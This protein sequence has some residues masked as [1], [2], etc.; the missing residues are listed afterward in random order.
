MSASDFSRGNEFLRNGQLEEAI[1]AYQKAIGQNRDFYLVYQNLGEALEKLGRFDEAIAAYRRAVELKPE[2]AWSYVNLSRVLRQVGRVDEAEN[3]EEQGGGIHPKLGVVRPVTTVDSSEAKA[4]NLAADSSYKAIKELNR[5]REYKSTTSLFNRS[6]TDNPNRAKIT[7]LLLNFKRY[8]NI[9]KIVESL[10][11]QT[12]PVEIFLWDNS[13]NINN[14]F[15]NIDLVFRASQNQGC[16][17]RWFMAL[18]A[19]TPYIMT[20]DD[21]FMITHHETIANIVRCLEEQ[22]DTRT[23][24]GLEGVVVN[25]NKSY[26]DHVLGLR[27]RYRYQGNEYGSVGP[28]LIYRSGK[29][30]DLIR[31]ERVHLV[32]GRLMATRTENIFRHVDIPT[33]IKERED[34]IA[35]SAM[36][37]QKQRIHLIPS[38][39][40]DC[41]DEL[42]DNSTLGNKDE[43]F[44]YHS[45]DMALKRYFI[46]EDNLI[47]SQEPRSLTNQVVPTL[48]LHQSPKLFIVVPFNDVRFLQK[49]LQ[50]IEMQTYKN[51]KCIVVDDFC[52]QEYSNEI[53]KILNCDN[54]ELVVNRKREY[55]LKSRVVA[56]E[57]CVEKEWISDED[58]I[59][60]VDGDDWLAHENSLLKIAE[61]YSDGRTWVTYGGAKRLEKGKLSE[62]FMHAL[63][64]KQIE[65]KWGLKVSPKYPEEVIAKRSY[66][67]YPWGACHCRT[68]KYKL[69]KNIS[70]DDFQDASGNYFRYATDMAIFVPILEMAGNRI[71]YIDETIYIYNRE[72]GKKN[73]ANEFKDQHSNHNY[74]RKKPKYSVYIENELFLTTK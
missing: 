15:P 27:S 73:V 3:A 11:S 66:R 10:R 2:A 34:D 29:N 6:I 68:F 28:S 40:K 69:Y 31:S 56:I 20:H 52:Q 65:E 64:N 21:D 17:P 12:I 58:V 33:L 23:I 1:A 22:Q 37:G 46:Q 9:P 55:A 54:F 53:R 50:S 19:K 45:R 70:K 44:H 14:F 62:P 67:G 72:T 74:I 51:F 41:I 42:D 7:I 49:C 16:S 35:V 59:V 39:F 71:K 38:F 63:S 5:K 57:R 8:H 61:A 25:P 32:K 60:H 48:M 18:Y 36:I 4:V 30:L 24:I 43:E 13:S 26:A 47:L